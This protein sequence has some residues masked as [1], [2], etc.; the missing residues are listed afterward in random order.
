M[1]SPPFSMTHL[2]RFIQWWKTLWISSNVRSFQA[3]VIAYSISSCEWN[4]RSFRIPFNIPKSQ[5]S[6]GLKSR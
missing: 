6:R 5:K 1:Y 4:S 3:I 2:S